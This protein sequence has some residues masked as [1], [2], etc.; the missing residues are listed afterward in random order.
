M[1]GGTNYW[2]QDE[3]GRDKYPTGLEAWVILFELMFQYL[4][5]RKAPLLEAGMRMLL[6]Q[7]CSSGRVDEHIDMK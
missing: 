6:H 7:S 3:S 2:K 4:P 1:H 5:C